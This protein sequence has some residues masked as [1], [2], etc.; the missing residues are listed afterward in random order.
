MNLDDGQTMSILWTARADAWMLCVL[1]DLQG[2]LKGV[3]SGG[4]EQK[5]LT[6]RYNDLLPL[7]TANIQVEYLSYFLRALPT[8]SDMI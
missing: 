7:E 6:T 1:G 8:G 3:R 2:R 5:A 4:W